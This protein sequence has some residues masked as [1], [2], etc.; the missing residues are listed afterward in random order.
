MPD[1]ERIRAAVMDMARAA[2]SKDW[3]TLRSTF[4]DEVDFDYTSVAGGKPARLRGDDIVTGWREGLG[5][6]RE[7]KHNFSDMAVK[8]EGD[9]AI[10]TFSGQATHVRD[11]NGKPVR[12]SCGGD[13][14]YGFTRTAQGWKVTSARFDMKWEQGTR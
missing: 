4:A 8:I 7:T 11:E 1:D 14:T 12:W 5:R 3:K 13:Y 9:K 6:Y 10:C 2:D